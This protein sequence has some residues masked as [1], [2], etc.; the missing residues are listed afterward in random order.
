[1]SSSFD[2][3]T[4][5]LGSD[6]PRRQ[7]LKAVASTF[8]ASAAAALFGS[9]RTSAQAPAVLHSGDTLSVTLG[10]K[11]PTG[12]RP[13]L[14]LPDRFQ[15][16]LTLPGQLP[17]VLVPHIDQTTEQVELSIYDPSYVGIDQADEPSVQSEGSPG[18]DVAFGRTVHVR[19]VS[20]RVGGADNQRSRSLHV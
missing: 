1:M 6:V 14:M 18:Y 19:C 13:H 17:C 3:L 20:R 11:L 2:R 7:A 8:M 5:T 4:G 15:G 9:Q 16:R 10:F 12:V